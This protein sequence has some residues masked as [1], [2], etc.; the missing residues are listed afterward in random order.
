MELGSRKI[1]IMEDEK[2]L[3]K[4]LELKL[5]HEGYLVTCLKNGED[6]LSL[7]EKEDFSLIVCDLMMPKFDGFQ[8]L[9]TLKEKELKIPVI[10]LTNLSQPED[11]KKVQELGASHFYVK[12]DIQLSQIISN[13]K[14]IVNL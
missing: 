13:I 9:Q 3:A 7:L 14:E 6:F 10:V 4:A 8:V 5:T 2:T 11:E 1:L 12:S